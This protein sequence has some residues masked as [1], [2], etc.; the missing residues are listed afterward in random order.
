MPLPLPPSLTRLLALAALG[1]LGACTVTAPGTPA[2]QAPAGTLS[3]YHWQ[4][5]AAVDAHGAQDTRWVPPRTLNQQ[6]LQL[7]F[8]GAQRLSIQGL[9]NAMGSG[10]QIDGNTIRLQP[11]AGTMRMCSQQDVMHYEREVANHLPRASRW[12]IAAAPG[13]ATPGPGA[14]QAPVLTL[15]F[16]DGG[17]WQLK[18]VPTDVTRYG[19]AGEIQFLEISPDTIA[20]NHPLMPGHACLNVREVYY[21]ANGIKRGHGPWQAFYGSIQGYTHQPGVRQVLRI[22]RYPLAQA[23]VDASRY[24]YVL[25]MAVEA[26]QVRTR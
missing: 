26:E 20:C 15:T 7:T 11:I 14:V 13:V 5:E 18:G 16:Q 19:S 25:D 6:P 4:L 3:A 12:E 2:A 1:G 21:D 9:C 22:K 10:Y 8:D 23:P 17:R 24:A